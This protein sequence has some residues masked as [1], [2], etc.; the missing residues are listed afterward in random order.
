VEEDRQKYDDEEHIDDERN[1][2]ELKDTAK[3]I[4]IGTENHLPMTRKA[5]YDIPIISIFSHDFSLS[6][7]DIK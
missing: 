5:F 3:H 6:V 2:T 1:K 4:S 7:S